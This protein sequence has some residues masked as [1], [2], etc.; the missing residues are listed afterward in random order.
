VGADG[1]PAAPRAPKGEGWREKLR[2][3]CAGAADLF[4]PGLRRTSSLLCV[5]WM[6]NALVYYSLVL[7]TTSVQT[8]AGSKPA[9]GD[10]GRLHYSS[11]EMGAIFADACAELPG[12]VVAA[13]AIDLIGR[14][15]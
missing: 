10:G 6:V 7:L 12:L 13:V 3:A 9:C 14:R 11:K 1:V 2:V 4:A 5:V 15:M 8:G